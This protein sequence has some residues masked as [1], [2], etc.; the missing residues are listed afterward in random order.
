MVQYR[1][2]LTM[3]EWYED[4]YDLSNDTVW[5]DLRWPL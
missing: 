1:A 4:V 5:N 2:T 3:V